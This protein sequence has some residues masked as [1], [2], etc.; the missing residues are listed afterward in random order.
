MLII[1]YFF[2]SFAALIW[3]EFVFPN[4]QSTSYLS[5]CTTSCFTPPGS[6]GEKESA[7]TGTR[8]ELRCNNV[9]FFSR[10]LRGHPKRG[11]LKGFLNILIDSRVKK[12]LHLAPNLWNKWYHSQHFLKLLNN[13]WEHVNDIM[14][15]HNVLSPY[16]LSQ[17][18]LINVFIQ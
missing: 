17:I 10:G 11:I 1:N 18:I 4:R 5:I 2:V 16:T 9:W 3:T 14:Y 13:F 7:W 12:R 15:R 8:P 6:L